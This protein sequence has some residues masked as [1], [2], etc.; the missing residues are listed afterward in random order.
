[1]NET[2][3]GSYI[4]VTG[5]CDA[6]GSSTDLI[7]VDS[8]GNITWSQ[9]LDMNAI[10][11]LQTNDTGYIVLGNGPLLGIH[12]HSGSFDPQIGILKTD[13]LG[14]GNDCAFPNNHF[15]SAITFLDSSI[16]FTQQSAGIPNAIFPEV[17]NLQLTIDNGCVFIFGEVKEEQENQMLIVPNPASSSFSIKNLSP[18]N[19]DLLEIFDAFGR[20]VF[21]KNISGSEKELFCPRL[22]A[23]IY[24][25]Q[26]S[27]EKQKTTR[28][29]VVE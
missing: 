20:T 10:E 9:T 23:G 5:S 1:M 24:L 29:L 4:Y 27:S 18:N 28:K 12:P 8:S 3:D 14:F 19:F 6:F 22:L 26:L 16:I 25:I 13:S 15:S 2:L 7:K 17:N 11:A 21:T